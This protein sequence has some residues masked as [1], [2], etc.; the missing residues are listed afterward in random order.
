MVVKGKT[1][2]AAWLQSLDY[3]DVRKSKRR[4]WVLKPW[5][6]FQTPTQEGNKTD[7]S[8][9][10]HRQGSFKIFENEN[11]HNLTHIP[12]KPCAVVEL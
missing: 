8:C 2:A 9:S 4:Q 11:S 10:D 1:E 5:R 3:N 12:F 7:A 6:L